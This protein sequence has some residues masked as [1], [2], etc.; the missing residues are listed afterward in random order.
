MNVYYTEQNAEYARQA[1][2]GK[3]VRRVVSPAKDE[4]LGTELRPSPETIK[5]EAQRRIDAGDAL[6]AT[7]VA[8]WD[9]VECQYHDTPFWQCT[10]CA[11]ADMDGGD[12]YPWGITTPSLRKQAPAWLRSVV[13]SAEK[14]PTEIVLEYGRQEEVVWELVG[15]DDARAKRDADADDGSGYGANTGGE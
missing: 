2:G 4:I 6:A 12:F 7:L 1:Y 9:N 15:A 11:L 8:I 14:V 5:A 13:R 3:V 10:S